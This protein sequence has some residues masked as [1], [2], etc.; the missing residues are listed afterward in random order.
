MRARYYS[1]D[2]ILDVRNSKRSD[3]AAS[4]YDC[5]GVAVFLETEKGQ[6]ITGFEVIGAKSALALNEGYDAKTDILL[7]G[8]MADDPALVKENGDFVTHWRQVDLGAESGLFPIGVGLRNAS[9]RLA[10]VIAS[11]QR[12]L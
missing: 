12:T 6:S 7:F 5:M 2:D 4:L 8:D 3:C 11:M 10:P 1:D 9:K